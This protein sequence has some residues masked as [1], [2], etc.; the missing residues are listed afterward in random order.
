MKS[1]RNMWLRRNPIARNLTF[2][3]LLSCALPG[4]VNATRVS[5]CGYPVGADISMAT[6][7][8]SVSYISHEL[9]S[10]TLNVVPAFVGESYYATTDAN[11]GSKSIGGFTG[12]LGTLIFDYYEYEQD[13]TDVSNFW[14]VQ[15][16]FN[17]AVRSIN[18]RAF[19]SSGDFLSVILLGPNNQYFGNTGFFPLYTD[20]VCQDKEFRSGGG[21]YACKKYVGTITAP[22][23][24]PFSSVIIG[25]ESA[26][27]WVRQITVSEPSVIALLAF[28]V[29]GFGILRRSHN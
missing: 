6:A 12:E 21:E 9:S 24:M 13:L 5:P 19:S 26:A 2:A 20:D 17:Q 27:A 23:G 29:I 15:A 4:T 11:C 10:P 28:G 16:D 3:L 7:G 1:T 8:V 22:N 14:G 25:S 18:I